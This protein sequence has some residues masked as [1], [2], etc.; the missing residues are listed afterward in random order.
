MRPARMRAVQGA[1]MVRAG[2]VT[3]AAGIML[4]AVCALMLLTACGGF[5]A[6]IT[7]WRAGSS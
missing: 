1:G 6:V 2:R 4:P 7:R 5:P 3:A